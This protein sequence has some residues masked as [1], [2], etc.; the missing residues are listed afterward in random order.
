MT[1]VVS[2][3]AR[4]IISGDD[5]YKVFWPDGT[6]GFLSAHN[7]REIANELD[8]QNKQW[9]HIVQTDP[10]FCEDEGCPHYG[11][12][13]SHVTK[14]VETSLTLETIRA[15]NLARIPTYRDKHGELLHKAADGSD[16]SVSDWFMAMMGEVGE[17]AN[18]LKKVKRGDFTQAEV[19]LEIQKEFAD[20]LAYFDLLALRCGIDLTAAYIAKFNEISDRVGSPVKIHQDGSSWRYDT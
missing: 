5:G 9:N 14:S 16:W 4:D 8:R 6:Q 17:L 19:Q 3:V 20:V 1:L 2:K 13:H 18:Y 15:A 11:K 12:P 10:V 7:L